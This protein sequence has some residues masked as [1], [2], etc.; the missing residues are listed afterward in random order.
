MK[1]KWLSVTCD[2]P[3][4]AEAWISAIG[5]AKGGL[6]GSSRRDTEERDAVEPATWARCAI[7][8]STPPP[9]ESADIGGLLQRCDGPARP[10][11]SQVEACGHVC[12][13]RA[14]CGHRASCGYDGHRADCKNRAD[15]KGRLQSKADGT[16]GYVRA[17]CG[18]CTYNG[19]D[20][21]R[22]HC[23]HRGHHSTDCKGWLSCEAGRTERDVCR[24]YANGGNRAC[25]RYG[26]LRTY[27]RNRADCTSRLSSEAARTNGYVC[28]HCGHCTYG[29]YDRNRTHCR[30]RGHS[31]D[32]K[33]R[34]SPEA[35]RTDGYVCAHSGHRANGG[36]D[37]NRTHYGHRG[38][39]ADCES[40]LSSEVDRIDG[41]GASCA[42]LAGLVVREELGQAGV[43]DG[44]ERSRNSSSQLFTELFVASSSFVF[45]EFCICFRAHP[46]CVIRHWFKNENV[47]NEND[48]LFISYEPRLSCPD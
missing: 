41:P 16:D 31:T 38:H 14:H 35:G 19:Y 45:W 7:N 37:R 12:K 1:V 9:T 43:K 4:D 29:G 26:G 42:E 22:T 2:T 47:E 18:H 33:S 6:L 11:G 28:A 36:Y 39:R 27:C 44:I 25:C 15:C 21:N 34:V 10:Q 40:P 8:L 32:C 17:H 13:H 46:A 24:Y 3:Q 5:G 20:R 23:R 48:K 30:H